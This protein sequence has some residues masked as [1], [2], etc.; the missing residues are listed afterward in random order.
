MS[1]GQQSLQPAGIGAV[2]QATNLLKHFGAEDCLGQSG[3]Q[4]CRNASERRAGFKTWHVEVDP[5]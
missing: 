3:E 2:E 5:P 1:A 4:A